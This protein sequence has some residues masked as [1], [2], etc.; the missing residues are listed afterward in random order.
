MAI[1]NGVA[2]SADEGFYPKEIEQSLRFNSADS[3]YLSWTP[4]SAGNRKTWTWSGWVKFNSSS[5][6]SALF[7]ANGQ[8]LYWSGDRLWYTRA[9]VGS[10]GPPNLIRDYSAWYHIVLSVDTTQ[11]TLAE[12]LKIYING[13]HTAHSGQTVVSQNFDTNINSV[14][15][16]AIASKAGGGNPAD[17]Y[18]SEVHFTDGTAYDATAFGEF[19]NGVWVA[20]EPDVTYGTNGFYLPFR[21]DYTV[22]GMST[23][24]YRGTGG[25]QYIGGVGFEPD[26]VWIKER[27]S[28]SSHHLLDSVRGVGKYLNSNNT[29]AEV[30]NTTSLSAFNSDGFTVGSSGG[31]NESSQGYVA[32]CWDAGSGSPASNTDGSIT[33]TVKANPDYGFSIVSWTG[34]GGTAANEGTVGHG[35]SS[36]PELFIAKNRDSAISWGVVTTAIDGT[37]DTMALDATNA[38]VDSG[39]NAPTANVFTVGG[40]GLNASGADH[41]AYCFHSVSGYSDFGSYTG[42][43]ASGNTVTTGFR[44]AFVMVKNTSGI[45]QWW[46]Y[47]NVRNANGDLT[48]TDRLFAESSAA[49]ST[50]GSLTVTDT[51]FE[52]NDGNSNL[53]TS[54][55][56]YIYMAFADTREAA[57]WLDDSGNNNDW[58]NNNLT[59][60]DIVLDS[61]TNN[62]ATLNP[63]AMSAN[64]AL[65]E[66]NL[67]YNNTTTSWQAHCPSTIGM[68][69]GKYYIE[70]LTTTEDAN[71]YNQIGVSQ[72]SYY[73]G[74][75]PYSD[76]EA[77]YQSDGRVWTGT[78]NAG[79]TNYGVGD[80]VGIQIDMDSKEC[81]F[82]VNGGAWFGATAGSSTP[83]SIS[84]DTVYLAVYAYTTGV[85]IANFGQDSSFAGNK[86]PQ[87]YTDANGIGDFYYQPPTGYLAL[88]TAN[89]PEP[90]IGPNS[91]S[92]SDEHFNTLV[93]SGDG[94]NT[95]RSFTGVGFQPD[96]M[97]WKKRSGAT[98]HHLYDSIR[99]AGNNNELV[100]N[101]TGAE[102]A[103]NAEIYGYLGS[104]DADGFTGTA[105][106]DGSFPVDYFNG[107]GSTYVAWNWK[108]NGSGSTNTDGSITSTVSAN[109]DAGFSIVSFTGDGT[110]TATV[111][112][113]LSSTPELVIVKQRNAADNWQVK[114]VPSNFYLTLDNTNAASTSYPNYTATSSVIN[115]GYSWNNDSGGTHIA[116][117]FHSVEGF[118]KVFSYTGNGSS[119]GTFVHLGFKPAFILWKNVDSGIASWHMM[120][121]ARDTYNVTNKQLKPNSSNAEQTV[122]ALDVLSNGFKWRDGSL[123]FNASGNNYI[124]IAFAENPFKYSNAR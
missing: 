94:T 55:E 124:G 9:G 103:S 112:H 37:V 24:T 102:G 86:T 32:W 6:D 74:S 47:D 33:S 75:N 8:G 10:Y 123:S 82:N 17:L 117:C 66:G 26:L 116:Y 16:H 83:I 101:S 96:L 43:G 12:Q 54:S 115:L 22:E 41:I 7:H 52:L 85:M 72:Y 59:E 36:A 108:A 90:V 84:A 107:T 95:S 50:S 89:L 58:E 23:V 80:I 2:K 63:I 118:S 19:K 4:A 28:T 18:L 30:D 93:W 104:F 46:M 39:N 15:A 57:F 99:G 42:T 67:R 27:T 31:T 87:G 61:P 34:T 13:E 68:S 29:N 98:V 76:L 71:Q 70:V 81:L 62:F 111:G 100:S 25:T 121:T 5:N 119:D 113:G 48:T 21:N 14:T 106:T 3:A 88:C 40:S 110:T 73:T 114:Y 78:A 105:G 92:A 49:E 53:N 122:T 79:H 1:I 51:G 109:T 97:W 60:S 77:S 45:G 91:A 44:P 35:L 20:K 38:K 11:S 56:T 65:K 69:S 120:D 64:G